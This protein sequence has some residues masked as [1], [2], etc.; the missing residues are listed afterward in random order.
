MRQLKKSE[1][2]QRIDDAYVFGKDDFVM[3]DE[4]AF[5]GSGFITARFK[6]FKDGSQELITTTESNIKERKLEL[7]IDLKNN[8]KIE[9][10]N[11]VISIYSESITMDLKPG[12]SIKTTRSTC[13]DFI[14]NENMGLTPIIGQVI[15]AK[16][17]IA[18]IVRICKSEKF[19][20]DDV[21][22]IPFVNVGPS[23][24]S[25]IPNLIYNSLELPMKVSVEEVK[26]SE[27]IYPVMSV[28]ERAEAIFLASSL[29]KEKVTYDENGIVTKYTNHMNNIKM[30]NVIFPN[31]YEKKIFYMGYLVEYH[32]ST[33]ENDINTE[34]HYD[35][36]SGCIKTI[37]NGETKETMPHSEFMLGFKV[38]IRKVEVV[39]NNVRLKRIYLKTETNLILALALSEDNIIK[40]I[41]FSSDKKYNEFYE[42]A[43]YFSCK[44]GGMFSLTKGFNYSL[45]SKSGIYASGICQNP[46]INPEDKKLR[47][48]EY[49]DVDV[50]FKTDDNGKVI[51]YESKLLDDGEFIYI[52]NMFGIPEL[53]YRKIDGEYM[54]V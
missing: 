31:G 24:I 23:Y 52:R 16:S 7:G 26:T 17:M 20:L 36:I 18:P 34:I 27:T 41:T 54:E 9:Y 39:E 21:L 13:G 8:V 12:L 45:S 15:Y 22:S 30:T 43:I 32:S 48:I 6:V 49:N 25:K 10:R 3:V 50:H 33:M 37:D 35:I 51:F 2:M 14:Y 44:S 19:M 47:F 5:N 11:N 53:R 29:G 28:K 4:F 46:Y 40:E 38:P 42:S 1:L